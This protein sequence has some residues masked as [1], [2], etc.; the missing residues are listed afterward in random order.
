MK[1]HSTGPG[2]GGDITRRGASQEDDDE[3]E[4]LIITGTG[5]A[6]VAGAD[7]KTQYLAST[8][9]RQGTGEETAAAFSGGWR[10]LRFPDDSSGERICSGRRLSSLLP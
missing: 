7:I 1:M 3:A 9:K 5:R 8:R 10:C 2:P 6:L 4:V